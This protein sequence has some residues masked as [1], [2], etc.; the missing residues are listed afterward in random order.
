M[1]QAG[2][3]SVGSLQDIET[4]TGN[5]GGAVGPT[6]GNVNLLGAGF[7]DVTGNLGTSTMT[8][9]LNTELADSFPTDL[10]TA[11]PAA[12]VL[13][14]RGGNNILTSGLGDTVTVATTDNITAVGSLESG[15]TLTVG[16]DVTF[17]SI[18]DGGLI[19]DSSGV[20]SASGA[21][22][23][24]TGFFSWAGG[25]PYFDDTTLG[26][27]TVSQGGTG[28]IKSVTVT[29][30]AGQT[31]TG[32]T[33]GNTYLI[34]IDDTGTIGK[35]TTISQAT[36]E[37]Y[38]VLF[39]CLR[40]STGTNNQYTV[41]E[42]HPSDFAPA[43]SYYLH[44]SIGSIIENHD[45]G[46]NITLNGTQKIEIVGAD[47]L[48]DHGLYTDS[49]DSGGVAETWNQMY[50]NG[51][52]KWATYTSSDTFDGYW[53]S[54]GTATAP[55]GNKY[56]TYTLYVSKDNI[57]SATPT[58][59]AV[60]NDSEYNNL[61]AAQ[62]A[63]SNGLVSI[64]TAELAKLEFAQLGHIIYQQSISTIVD[65][66]I[67]KETLKATTAGGSGTNDASLVLTNVSNFDGI[68]SASDT[69]VQV[70]LET[71]DEWGKST[72]NN[73]L[74]VG[75]GTG[76]GLGSLAVGATGEM[77]IG[78]TGADPSW[79]STGALTTLNATTVNATTFDTNIAAA[80]VTLAG[81][82]LA[83][84][85]TDAYIDINITSKGT[86]QVII[87]DLQLTTDLAV[88]EGGTG[89]S[90]LTDHGVL[91]G[92]GASAVTPLAVGTNGQLLIGSTGADP[93]FAD[94]T[95]SGGTITI[96]PGAGTLNIETVGGTGAANTHTISPS[97]ADY[98]TIQAA[99]DDNVTANSVFLVYPGTYSGDTINFTAN[100]QMVIGIGGADGESLQIVSA[101]SA[102]ICDFG[103]F[104][105]CVVKNI[106]LTIS[107][108]TTDVSCVLGSTGSIT[109]ENCTLNCTT[110]SAPTT[111]PDCINTTGAATVEVYDSNINY[112]NPASVAA[113]VKIAI[114]MGLNSSLLLD[115]VNGTVACSNSSL[116][117]GFYFCTVN[118]D[119]IVRR[120]FISITDTTGGLVAAIYYVG[121]PANTTIIDRTQIDV[122]TGAANAGA[123]IYSAGTSVINSTYNK[124]TTTSL[125]GVSNSYVV[126]VGTTVT[127]TFDDVAA[128][129]GPSI[130]GT[131]TQ[132]NSDTAGTLTTTS[133]ISTATVT[134]TNVNSTTF[135]TNVAAAAVT[136]S[137]TSL[138]ADGTDADIDIIITAKGTGQVIVDDLQLTTP[139]KVSEGGTGTISLTDNAVLV[140]SGAVDA[141]EALPLGTNGQVLIGSTG[142]IPAFASLASADNSVE[143]TSGAA[144]LDLSVTGTV[145]INAQTGTSYTLVL[146]DAGK[147]VTCT[148]AA[149]ITLTVPPNS[150]VAFDTG[151]TIA[152]VQGGAGTVTFSPG[153]GVT[154]N[155][156]GSAL[157]TAGQYAAASLIK[158]ATNTWILSGDIT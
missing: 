46:A 99:L 67:E 154:I 33:A 90:T 54:A 57:N 92:S 78:N 152:L 55:T 49:P 60:L 101:A 66:I 8:I 43:V 124:I 120:S 97:G 9:E 24:F 112:T 11:V 27:F 104:T 75:N 131:F 157:D 149:A 122:T 6:A 95:S 45:N 41:K 115:R 83:A 102:D 69:T 56:S 110:A 44:E 16:T 153:S 34:Y 68:L 26:S 47:E 18:T 156:R 145:A 5:T 151:T 73:A 3:Y 130:G 111:Q 28:F 59:W 116:G 140:G 36:Y 25:A 21:L 91:V 40:D 144:T 53:N 146:A 14:I 128:A 135:D 76:S 109:I 143:Y 70:S 86:G 12:G 125:G 117:S 134:A 38:I 37:D 61:T 123:A 103:A 81:T 85:G 13:E 58:Y 133:S 93:V 139:L 147:L 106:T 141:I 84:D 127:A 107:A 94:L 22:S 20:V 77:L 10:G 62:T 132:V 51:A 31:V 2:Q 87:D 17:T 155:S 158:T 148:N 138:T 105:G 71:I 52:G 30:A 129:S 32:L 50:T 88:T 150:S 19:V 100:N 96:T 23:I 1:S 89:A 137:G 48:A 72:T 63:I 136:L 98:T 119:L 108:A 126:G 142:A 74:I 114:S 113:E 42:N 82:T 121:A 79:S 15:T 39:E 64:A 29:W 118:L 35:T 4:L 65:V 80:A 7:I